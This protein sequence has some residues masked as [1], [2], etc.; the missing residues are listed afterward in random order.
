MDRERMPAPVA[1]IR[2]SRK[3]LRRIASCAALVFA[4][5]C[6]SCRT[7]LRVMPVDREL[8]DACTRLVSCKSLGDAYTS[9][10]ECLYATHLFSLE[11]S[12]LIGV[13][14]VYVVRLS[15]VSGSTYC[16]QL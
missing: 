9:V 14:P 16:S 1:A 6:S 10:S 13:P 5:L 8:A 4:T 15:C 2:R 12:R 7:R 11:G 3:R